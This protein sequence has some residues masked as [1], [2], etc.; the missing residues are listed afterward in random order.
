ML[1]FSGFKLLI[2]IVFLWFILGSAIISVFAAR[3]LVF[4]IT[5][6]N[7]NQNIN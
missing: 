3:E 6:K 4:L 1:S 2:T 5:K 7:K